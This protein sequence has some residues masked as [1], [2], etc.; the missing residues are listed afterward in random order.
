M[1]V[2]VSGVAY[3]AVA[4]VAMVLFYRERNAFEIRVR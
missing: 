2:L 1:F 3:L 4:S